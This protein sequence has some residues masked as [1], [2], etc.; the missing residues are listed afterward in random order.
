MNQCFW[1]IC[2]ALCGL[3]F[4]WRMRA[5]FRRRIP[6]GATAEEAISF[7]RGWALWIF[8][9]CVA[10]WLLRQS[11]GA[12]ALPF[13]D[14]WPNPQRTIALSLQVFLWAALLYWVFVK[15]GAT[16]LSKFMSIAGSGNPTAFKA[17]CVVAVLA[18]SVALLSRW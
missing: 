16:T 14:E 5:R 17:V 1:L 9:P 18:G 10:F 13:C 8:L 12:E 2:G 3:L 15:D 4:A 6:T 11:I 7:T